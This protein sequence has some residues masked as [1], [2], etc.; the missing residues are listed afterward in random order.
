MYTQDA[1]CTGKKLRKESILVGEINCIRIHIGN[2]TVVL[3][4]KIIFGLRRGI[5]CKK[6]LNV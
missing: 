1:P 6:G 5:E 3:I 2:N 4:E